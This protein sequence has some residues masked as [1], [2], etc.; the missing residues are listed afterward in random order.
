VA[1][2]NGVKGWIGCVLI[3]CAVLCIGCGKIGFDQGLSAELSSFGDKEVMV[4]DVAEDEIAGDLRVKELHFEN[5]GG[6]HLNGV[7]A[8]LKF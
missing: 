3:G 1:D 2:V 6:R 4:S 7:E 8:V 5:E